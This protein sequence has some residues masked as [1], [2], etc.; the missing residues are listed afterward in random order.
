MLKMG[1]E[2]RIFREPLAL[3]LV[4]ALLTM[5]W[6]TSLCVGPVQPPVDTTTL[7]VGTFGWGPRRADPVR[8]YDTYGCELI[9]N[10]YDT[11]ISMGA[12][13]TNGWGTWDVHE[14][15]WE[16]SPNLATDVPTREDVTKDVWSSDVNLSDPTGS[17][18]SDGSRCVGWVDN[19][20][21]SSLDASD[22]LYMFE[23]VG[24]YRTWFVQ[25]LNAGPPVS[26]SLWR[27]RY[28]FHMRTTPVISFVNETG[29]IVDTFDVYD[30]EYSFERGLVQ[31]QAGSPMWM[32]YEPFFDQLN[33][34]PWDPTMTGDNATTMN[35]AYL[36]DNAI[37]ASGND[38]IINVGIPFP[39][40]AFK[41]ILS[42]TWGSIVSKEFSVSIGCWNGDID[43]DTNG[44]G[45]PD[46][47]F[48]V[49]R[50]SRSSYDT[51]GALRYVGS[52][53]YRVTIFDPVNYMVV[54][55]RNMHYWKGW[56]GKHLDKIEIEYIS[57]VTTRLNA[58]IECRIDV[59]TV[60][61]ANINQL[62]DQYGEPKYPEIKTIKYVLPTLSIEV[63]LFQ[64]SIDPSSVYIGSGDFPNGVPPNFFNNTHVRKAFAYGFD[65]T[66]YIDGVWMGEAMWRETPLINGL[67]PDYYSKGP[68]PP[69]IYNI[70][71][72]AAEAELK[73]AIFD[74]ESVWDSGFTVS[75]PYRTGNYR[76]RIA[77][78]I[79]RDFF[80]NL[81]TYDSRTGPTFTVNVVGEWSWPPWPGEEYYEPM[82]MNGWL[83]DFADADNFVRPYMYSM[84][85]FAWFQNYTKDNGWGARKDELIDLALKTPDGPERA[86]LYT[87]LQDIYIADCPSFPIAQIS[88]RRW[89]K[90][91]VKGWYH[92][93][94]YP[95]TYYYHIYKED[96]C[97]ADVTSDVAGVPDGVCNMRDIGYVALHFGTVAPDISSPGIYDVNWAPGTYGCGGC[98]VYGDRLI[99]MRDIGEAC[100]HFLH[101]T[102]P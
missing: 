86:S 19:H 74:E 75:L 12:P 16:F 44:D 47:W 78:E 76:A 9:F 4:I 6:S 69:Y 88:G 1:G 101:T 62:V 31:D 46:W 54:M 65:H 77:W 21:T 73:Q 93:G 17:N 15:Y 41:Q 23:A 63:A 67:V 96:A 66:E 95:A 89:Q 48:N 64:L 43:G 45:I 22:V 18:W 2:W 83:A 61:S 34:N 20:A 5:L 32:Y 85:D 53:P 28:T 80:T 91:W 8:V 79:L 10:V 71:Y 36:I 90:Y 24:S 57:D 55:E 39:D 98:D 3:V 7:Y 51:A 87:E 11:L 56:A 58:F 100:K 30:A 27:G 82:F 102:E 52:G 29:A 37:E 40:I 59:C 38:L 13:V 81:S 84:G 26:V 99:D 49:R 60:P 68:D 35:L 33:S 14:Q 25:S 72:D 50:Q 70:N 92:N 94:L 42:Q 97:W